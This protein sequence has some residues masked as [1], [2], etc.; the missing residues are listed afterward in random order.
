MDYESLA[1]FRERAG[2]EVGDRWYPRITSILSIK[3]KPALYRYFARM[4]DWK[5]AEQAKE[6][7]AQEGTL[8]HVTVESILK[9]MP[10]EVDE[11][12]R[13]SVDAFLEFRRHHEVRPLLIEE[14]LVSHKHGYAGTIDVM[15]E[16]DGVVGVL[17]I[18]TSKA[19]YRDYGLQTAAYQQALLERTDVPPPATSWILR[20]D[21]AQTCRICGASMRNKGGNT[22]VTGGKWRCHHDWSAMTG[23]FEF[24][25]ISGFE[26]N[27]KGFLAAKSLW[28]WEHRSYLSRLA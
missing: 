22:R 14:R 1:D 13:P 9:G 17:D 12:I 6:R 28:E 8:V 10:M 24:T 5:T 4:P 27:L 21:Q 11:G 18:K 2:Y 16:V 20:L 3:A 25:E 26:H 7:S 23:Q 19:V 15:A